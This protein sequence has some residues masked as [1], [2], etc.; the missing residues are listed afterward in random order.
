M[1]ASSASTTSTTS[2]TTS[3]LPSVSLVI[4]VYN[5]KKTIRF[6]LDSIMQLDYPKDRLEVIVVDNNSKDETPEIV[7]QYPVKLVF[8]REKQGPHQATNT[9]LREAGGEIIA[10]TDSDCYVS[11]DWL[12]KLV[13]PFANPDVVATGGKIDAYTPDSQVEKYLQRRFAS[14]NGLRIADD[15]P[16]SLLTANAAYRAE[17]VRV[18]GCFNENLYTGA[19][20]DLAWR[21]QW[22]TGKQVVYVP[23]AVIYHKFSPG[24][25]RLFR[26]YHIYGYSEII[27]GTLYKHLPSYPSKPGQQVRFMLTQQVPSLFIY[28]LSLLIRPVRGLLSKRGRAYADYVAWPMMCLMA[29]SGSLYGKLQGLWHTRFYTRPFWQSEHRVI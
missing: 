9:G 15:F 10:F 7:K 16:A 21:V 26:H 5:G 25:K 23:D 1:N 29:E 11:P 20:V 14:Q 18:A 4:P 22:Q 3:S 19:E 12:R 28:I 17:A 13:A 8:E 2:A 6:C 24:L 27:L